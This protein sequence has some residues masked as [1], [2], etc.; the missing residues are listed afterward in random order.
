MSEL[1]AVPQ[2][3]EKEQQVYEKCIAVLNGLS[4]KE[5]ETILYELLS[6]IKTCSVIAF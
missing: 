4:V 1:F 2:L 5:A 3:T 6:N